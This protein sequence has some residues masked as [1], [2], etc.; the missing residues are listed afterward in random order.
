MTVAAASPPPAVV[1]LDD[2]LVSTTHR[3][4]NGGGQ[5]EGIYRLVP[6]PGLLFKRY[7]LQ[8]AADVRVDWLDRLVAQPSQLTDPT[9]VTLAQESIAWPRCRV[10]D[11]VRT[12]GVVIPEAPANLK[13]SRQRRGA[14]T[15]TIKHEHLEIDLLAKPNDYLTGRGIRA[16]SP[17]DRERLCHT[18][19]RIA[20]LFE[21][22]GIVYAD[23]S[24][25]NAFWHPGDQR[26]FLIDMDSCSYGPRKHVRTSEFDDPLTPLGVDVDCYVDRY[27]AALL[28]ARCFTGERDV[29]RVRSALAALPGPVPDR[30]LHMLVATS[31]I[32]RPTLTELADAFGA[33][34]TASHWSPSGAS[35]VD[36]TGVVGWRPRSAR[37]RHPTAQP[38]AGGPSSNG[39]TPSAGS[40]PARP[41]RP[42][43][44]SASPGNRPARPGSRP[45]G[46]ATAGP[47]HRPQRSTSGP[48]G[49]SSVPGPR[50]NPAPPAGPRNTGSAAAGTAPYGQVRTPPARPANGS[51]ITGVIG[52]FVGVCLVVA[53]IFVILLLCSIL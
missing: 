25:A 30:L 21:R 32:Q 49:R 20:R 27:R 10:V 44:N 38:G 7:T 26:V 18:L 3:L 22:A 6:Y 33:S 9:D 40:P 17:A 2:L 24:Y 12:V 15:S 34:P 28:I 31:R 45:S 42:A 5:S 4:H 53:A 35:T 29:T 16:Q 51:D 50:S 41:A 48:V 36:D 14:H 11:G 37:G 13:V 46:S 23:W 47:T 8:A 39:R 43:R 1:Q 52:G 19:A